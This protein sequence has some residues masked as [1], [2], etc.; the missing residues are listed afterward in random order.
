MVRI[1][2]K[3][4]GKLTKDE[5]ASW[6]RNLQPYLEKPCL[7][8]PEGYFDKNTINVEAGKIITYGDMLTPTSVFSILEQTENFKALVDL[9]KFSED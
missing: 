9:Y 1:G 4:M 8:A 3:G 2:G 7:L 6:I 5:V